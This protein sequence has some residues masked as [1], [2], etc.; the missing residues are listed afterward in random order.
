MEHS[1]QTNG[2]TSH[3]LRADLFKVPDSLSSK[4][5]Q[6]ELID[7][8][9][10]DYLTLI[11]GDHNKYRKYSGSEGATLEPLPFIGAIWRADTGENSS[12]VVWDQRRFGPIW[13]E[14]VS[15]KITGEF[16]LLPK[17]RSPRE[18]VLTNLWRGR[19]IAARVIKSMSR[20]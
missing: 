1:V 8:F 13:G 3:I 11:L 20:T 2:A 16:G 17:K 6:N 7:A 19:N 4:S 9:G 15:P 14:Y 18:F 12:R 5:T 10:L